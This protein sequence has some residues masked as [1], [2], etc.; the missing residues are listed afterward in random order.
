MNLIS[1]QDLQVLAPS[2][3]DLGDDNP[4]VRVHGYIGIQRRG[5]ENLYFARLADPHM[6]LAIQLVFD[7]AEQNQI[8]QGGNPSHRV[9][10]TTLVAAPTQEENTNL[11]GIDKEGSGQTAGSER[12]ESL[13]KGQNRQP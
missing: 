7:L 5:G 1:F 6:R 13:Q 8:D 4:E 11:G 2:I 3:R 9:E 10:S 12:T